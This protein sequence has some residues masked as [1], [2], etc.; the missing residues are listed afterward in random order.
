MH[1]FFLSR[2]SRHPSGAESK[3]HFMH[4]R[5]HVR[6]ALVWP[7]LKTSHRHAPSGGQGQGRAPGARKGCGAPQL[8]RAQEAGCLELSLGP[9]TLWG[10]PPDLSA[11]PKSSIGGRHSVLVYGGFTLPHR[12]VETLGRGPRSEPR[13][14]MQMV[15]GAL[16]SLGV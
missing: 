16:G 4:P 12:L 13:A 6:K 3:D 14:P 9:R 10:Y 15:S 2:L 5:S 7:L 11:R 1:C 8:R